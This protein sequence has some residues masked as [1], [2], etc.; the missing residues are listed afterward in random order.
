MLASRRDLLRN[1]NAG[2]TLPFRS[3]L[4]KTLRGDWQRQASLVAQT[5]AI[6]RAVR[7]RLPSG[8][9]FFSFPIGL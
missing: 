1:G 3:S 4:H 5:N 9:T 2:T 8:G 6:A 7:A